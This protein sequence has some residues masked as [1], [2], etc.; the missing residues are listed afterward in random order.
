M[1]FRWQR[2]G[3]PITSELGPTVKVV[4]FERLADEVPGYEE[5]RVTP[6]QWRERIAARKDAFARR[7][8]S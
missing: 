4:P 2:V 5:L 1:Q 6:E 7:G 3:D 8:L